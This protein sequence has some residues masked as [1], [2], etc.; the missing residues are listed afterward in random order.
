MA[1]PCFGAAGEFP[2]HARLIDQVVIDVLIGAMPAGSFQAAIGPAADT[3][4]RIFRF[5]AQGKGRGLANVESPWNANKKGG[6]P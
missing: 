5:G 2:H 6:K 4:R 3:I 1:W